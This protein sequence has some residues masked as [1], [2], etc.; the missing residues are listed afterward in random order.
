MR[1]VRSGIINQHYAMWIADSNCTE[2]QLMFFY[3]NIFQQY[4]T[5]ITNNWN[6][7]ACERYRPHF[8]FNNM[9]LLEHLCAH[10]AALCFDREWLIA[11]QFFIPQIT[12]KYSKPIAN[13]FSFAAI[14]IKNA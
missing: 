3:L 1:K 12:A 7:C 9:P 6:F 13:F 11:N 8:Y 10:N 14:W 2:L 5:R 4:I